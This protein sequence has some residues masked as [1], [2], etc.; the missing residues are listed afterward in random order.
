MAN[1]NEATWTFFTNHGH[2]LFFLAANPD[3]RARDIA[4]GVQ[5]TE[6]AAQRIVHELEAAGYLRIVKKGR[7]NSYVVNRKKKLRHPLE[8]HVPIEA[9]I[10]VL[11]A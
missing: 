8:E 3:A 9:L 2:V 4:D 11:E 10:E 1:G 6:R 5:I 7:R